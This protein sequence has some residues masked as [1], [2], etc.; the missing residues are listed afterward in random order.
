MP[1]AARS[2]TCAHGGQGLEPGR[3]RSAGT[4]AFQVQLLPGAVGEG[5]GAAALRQLQ[6]A[7]KR[8]A[9][10]AT[11]ARAAERRADVEERTGAVERG[12]RP[13]EHLDWLSEPL[14]GAAF[15]SDQAECVQSSADTA[16]HAGAAR[17]F[18]LVVQDS[19]GLV[20]TAEPGNHKGSARAPR[21]KRRAGRT[22][23]VRRRPHLR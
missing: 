20:R 5:R 16:R 21:D 8:L 18:E 23:S 17:A 12:L 6:A 1:R 22:R 4:Y 19:T 13:L 10:L 15:P 11:L 3:D 7:S 14:Q 9:G 2:A